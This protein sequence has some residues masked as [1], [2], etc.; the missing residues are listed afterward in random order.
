MTILKTVNKDESH[1][2]YLKHINQII[3]PII[4]ESVELVHVDKHTK[5]NFS[6]NLIVRV[7]TLFL[8]GKTTVHLSALC[9]GQH[10]I[11]M[12]ITAIIS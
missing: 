6:S 3:Q 10:T 1:L 7:S 8:I 5:H 12:E 9:I 11:Y 4:R 2:L